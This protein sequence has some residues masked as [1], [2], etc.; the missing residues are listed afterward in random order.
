MPIPESLRLVEFK[1]GRLAFLIGRIEDR[2]SV[3]SQADARR[4][5]EEVLG[6]AR[7]ELGVAFLAG[8][9]HEFFLLILKLF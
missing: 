1:D 4:V 7:D 5:L 2:P 3:R 6:R 9:E 8:P